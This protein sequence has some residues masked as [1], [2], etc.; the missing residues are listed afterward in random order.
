MCRIVRFVPGFRFWGRFWFGFWVGGPFRF[1]P[2]V[3]PRSFG[4]YAAPIFEDFS[5]KPLQSFEEFR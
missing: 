5:K 2:V 3:W 1:G 4:A